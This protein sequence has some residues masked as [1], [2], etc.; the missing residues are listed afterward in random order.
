MEPEQKSK[1]PIPGKTSII[2]PPLF[3]RRPSVEG[4]ER[5]SQKKIF[6][7]AAAKEIGMDP[8]ALTKWIRERNPQE[9]PGTN[10]KKRIRVDLSFNFAIRPFFV[11]EK[12][13]IHS[14]ISETSL[15]TIQAYF[16]LR[17]RIRK[18]EL[19][20]VSDGL[21]NRHRKYMDSMKEFIPL[22]IRFEKDPNTPLLIFHRLHLSR[23]RVPVYEYNGNYYCKPRHTE[24]IALAARLWCGS[25]YG[26]AREVAKVFDEVAKCGDAS[27]LPYELGLKIW[28][29]RAYSLELG[30][31][32]VRL[33]TDLSQSR[34]I[35]EFFYYG[36][37]DYVST[38]V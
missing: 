30:I 26:K 36:Q 1:L 11:E 9:E 23:F 24:A 31:D 21:G 12:I 29:L 20:P 3:P 33:K 17:E 34:V 2:P 7:S 32:L 28:V 19:I 37:K 38:S 16:A 27:K 5:V 13:G 14:L 4:I 10:G 35:Q 22:R 6:L 25:H 15:G 8:G 18:G